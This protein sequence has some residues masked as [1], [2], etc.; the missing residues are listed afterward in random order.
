[1]ADDIRIEITSDSS[2]IKKSLKETEKLVKRFEKVNSASTQRRLKNEQK[3]THAIQRAE[4]RKN[5]QL[6]AMDRRLSRKRARNRL[7]A[8]RENIRIEK[9]ETR[10]RE[11]I[12]KQAE[13]RRRKIMRFAGVIT[14][15]GAVGAIAGLFAAGKRIAEYEIQ[16]KRLAADANLSAKAEM[17]LAEAIKN[18]ALTTGTSRELLVQTLADIQKESGRLDIA[19]K[20]IQKIGKIIR[21]VGEDSAQSVGKMYASLAYNFANTGLDLY[22]MLEII[23][24]VGDKGVFT[25]DMFANNAQELITTFKSLGMETEIAWSEFNALIQ[26]FAAGAGS[27]EKARTAVVNYIGRLRMDPKVIK[28]FKATGIELKNIDGTERST[29][30]VIKD[31]GKYTEGDINLFRQLGFPLETANIIWRSIGSRI[32]KATGEIKG[33]SELIDAAADSAG[34][35]DR[36]FGQVSDTL[37]QSYKILDSLVDVLTEETLK[38]FFQELTNSFKNLATN[39]AA[40]TELRETFKTIGQTIKILGAAPKAMLWLG[41]ILGTGA[42]ETFTS[43]GVTRRANEQLFS[44]YEEQA[45]LLKASRTPKRQARL[46]ELVVTIRNLEKQKIDIL[47]N[48]MTRGAKFTLSYQ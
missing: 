36:K 40:L 19:G 17:E 7:R 15:I 41:N 8:M 27:A 1:M 10:A 44:L 14:G 48:N 32:N 37:D 25:L 20:D 18:T 35:I 26:L 3:A 6:E 22:K 11:R 28:G 2:E 33:L 24:A 47:L 43:A 21:V 4:A 34:V 23:T 46:D 42:S 9:A 16:L 30:E 39:R 12:Q 31:I 5:R 45:E 38:P 13:A 29:L